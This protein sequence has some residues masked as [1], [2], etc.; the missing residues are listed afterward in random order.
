MSFLKAQVSFPPNCTLIVNAIKHNS[1]VHFQLKHY[2][3]RSQRAHQ[4]AK[5]SGLSS[6]RVKIR[7]ISQ[8]NFETTSQLL[9]KFFIY[10]HCQYTNTLYINF[11][12]MRFL[13]WTKGS[14]QDLNFQTFNCYGENAP[15]FSCHFP[16]HKSVFL[17][18]LH[19]SSES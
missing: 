1:L 11:Q 15:N 14:H 17:Q 3:L 16:N 7:Q 10:P 8:F 4:S 13:L 5:C 9:F 12:L 18:I 6:D 2:I 19:Q